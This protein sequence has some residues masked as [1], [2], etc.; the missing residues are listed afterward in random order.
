MLAKRVKKIKPSPTLAVSAKIKAMKAQGIDVVGFG[1]GEP[2]FDTPDNIKA[3]AIEAINAGFTKYCPVEGIPELKEAIV[4]KIKKELG[5]EY[6]TSEVIVSCGAKHSIYN[7][8]MSLVDEGDE[9][10]IPAP[11]WVSYPDM[12]LLC[13]GKPK[14]I[15]T[16]EVEG[17]KLDPDKLKR[18]ITPKTKV[19]ILNSPSNPAGVTY[20]KEELEDIANVLLKHKKVFIISDDIYEKLIYDGL[21]FSN[22][23]QACPELK[24]RTIIVNGVSKTYSMTGWR[25][26]YALG[27]KP[28]IDA[29]INIQS[30]STSN[31]TSISMKAAVEALK[32]PQEAVENMR[33]EF[34]ERR[35]I[36]VEGLNAIEGVKCLKPKGAFYVFPN[37]SSTF[38]KK[39]PSKKLINNSLSFSEALLEEA[40]VGVVPGAEFGAE[41][42]IRLSYATSRENIKKGLERIREF[43][44]SLR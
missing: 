33:R 39:S 19:L 25:I 29:M 16:K 23:V 7:A 5:L 13:G 3:K 1:A 38:G 35:N 44:F 2:D 24:E 18:A 4:E 30:Q 37:I 40:K 17:F 22:I 11:Y 36:I 9:V 6:K 15:K 43:I 42:Y 41:G 26:G 28:V 8:L 21:K 31:P 34:E 27:P 12:V 20:T 14:I 10:L 32:G